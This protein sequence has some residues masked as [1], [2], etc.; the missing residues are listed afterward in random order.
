MRALILAVLLSSSAVAQ[1]VHVTGISDRILDAAGSNL[2]PLR[3]KLITVTMDGKEYLLQQTLR[4]Q[5]D[6]AYQFEVGA[7]YKVRKISKSRMSVWV[8]DKKGHRN[9]E[10]FAIR[11]I[12]R[13]S[14]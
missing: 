14:L 11:D 13:P 5:F 8:I 6:R 12:E 9:H 3:A 1:T 4:G 2:E 7:D 10:D